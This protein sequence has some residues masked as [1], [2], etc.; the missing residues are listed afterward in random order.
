MLQVLLMIAVV[1][2]QLADLLK[3]RID[4]VVVLFVKPADN[5]F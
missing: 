2:R 4:G 3:Q 1:K 5:A